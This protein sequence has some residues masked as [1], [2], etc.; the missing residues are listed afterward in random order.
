MFKNEYLSDTY[1]IRGD[2]IIIVGDILREYLEM[3]EGD[4]DFCVKIFGAYISQAKDY[5][6]LAEKCLFKCVEVRYDHAKHIGMCVQFYR[7]SPSLN[8]DPPEKDHPPELVKIPTGGVGFA[9]I[10][11]TPRTLRDPRDPNGWSVPVPESKPD[12][13]GDPHDFLEWVNS[14]TPQVGTHPEVYRSVHRVYPKLVFKGTRGDAFDNWN[15]EERRIWGE[16]T[17]VIHRG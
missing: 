2:N 11:P 14:R 17:E 12:Y 4:Y 10:P 13:T 3:Y 5:L 8:E 6:K 7:E 16:Q 9:T 15:M 1:K